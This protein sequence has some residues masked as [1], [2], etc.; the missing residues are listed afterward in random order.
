LVMC[1]LDVFVHLVVAQVEY[2][3]YLRHINIFP[4]LK[5]CTW[6]IA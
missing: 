2:N 4:L 5:K 1:I 3:W 6:D